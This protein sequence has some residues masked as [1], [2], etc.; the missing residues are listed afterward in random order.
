MRPAQRLEIRVGLLILLGAVAT[1]VMIMVSN[2]ISFEHYYRVT[3]YMA[4]ATGLRIG[5]PVTLSGV[6]IGKVSS[7]RQTDDQRGAI[8]VELGVRE[9]ARIPRTSTVE[10]ASSGIF[11]DSSVAFTAHGRGGDYIADDGTAEMVAGP[12]FFEETM[13]Q[14]K[15]IMRSLSGLLDDQTRDDAKRL[16]KNAADLAGESAKL[17]KGLN[18]QNARLAEVVD[19]LRAITSDL[20]A[21]V[22]SFAERSDSIAERIDSTL[23]SVQKRVEGVADSADA[24]IGRIDDLA[25]HADQ[26]LVDH[27]ADI[28]VLLRKARDAMT[29]V[30]SITAAID[31]G[32]G[33]IGQLVF[34]RDLAKDVNNLAIDLSVAA[35]QLNEHP[36]N[37]VWGPSSSERHAA[38]ARRQR[39]KMARAFDLDFGSPAP[40]KQSAEKQSAEQ[41]K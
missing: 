40:E 14:A 39:L 8:L 18:D 2:K 26:I 13:A 21:A 38:D 22:A 17:A 20:K 41:Q 16:V 4:D 19:N 28:A 12:G 36:S 35:D 11:G 27:R 31:A 32:Q 30:A 37:L 3:V 34:N 9:A 15:G 5:S 33:V 29:H 6:V 24:A 10:M 1:V 25:G 23:G 7:V